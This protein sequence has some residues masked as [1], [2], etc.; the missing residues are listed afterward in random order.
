MRS[1]SVS[2]ARRITTQ[3][4]PSPRRRRVSHPSCMPCESPGAIRLCGEEKN[5]SLA[6]STT[7][8]DNDAATSARPPAS[9]SVRR[10]GSGS[11]WTR[12]LATPP[13]GKMLSRRWVDPERRGD[14]EPVARIALER[15]LGQQVEPLRPRDVVLLDHRA[16][17]RAAVRVVAAEEAGV[18]DHAA[19]DPR[20]AEADD[21]PVVA[22]LAAAARLPA[23][24]LLASIGVAVG[25]EDRGLRLEEVLLRREELVVR[26]EHH[27]A[28]A[29]GGEVGQRR[30][31]AHA[32]PL[33]S[34]RPAGSS[35]NRP[36]A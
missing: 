19:D 16:L 5:R 26:D 25:V 34:R 7:P 23:V 4:W 12:S 18:D 15:R 13:S 11:P 6:S 3:S 20:D 27:P 31:V 29:P 2:V 30:E 14:V 33:D 28:E 10:S 1:I 24:H 17:D 21:A 9:V 32:A 22:R 36:S 35:R 8:P